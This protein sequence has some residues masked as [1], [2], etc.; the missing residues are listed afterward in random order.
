MVFSLLS[1]LN[2][3]S[4]ESLFEVL[5]LGDHV[6]LFLL[7]PLALIVNSVPLAKSTLAPALK[8]L[9]LTLNVQPLEFGSLRVNPGILLE[10]LMF[11]LVPLLEV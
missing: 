3:A 7:H 8:V 4:V 11:P 1:C 5:G 2:E 9:L 10:R 6:N